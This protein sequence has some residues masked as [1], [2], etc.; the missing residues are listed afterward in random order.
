MGIHIT[1]SIA[2]P[3]LVTYHLMKLHCALHLSFLPLF[4]PCPSLE[5]VLPPWLMVLQRWGKVELALFLSPSS[6][7]Q[8]KHQQGKSVHTGLQKAAILG[9]VVLFLRARR[10]FPG[11]KTPGNRSQTLF[12]I[13]LASVEEA[14]RRDLRSSSANLCTHTDPHPRSSNL[15]TCTSIRILFSESVSQFFL[16]RLLTMITKF[17]SPILDIMWKA[18]NLRSLLWKSICLLIIPRKLNSNVFC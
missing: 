16:A 14:E 9:M 15:V 11:K 3:I 1:A 18:W 8:A 6:S 17:V 5:V 7:F 4:S 12:A 13:G 2:I 10:T